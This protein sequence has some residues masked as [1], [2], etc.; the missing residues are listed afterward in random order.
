[1]N[2]NR[3]SPDRQVGDGPAPTDSLAIR[4]EEEAADSQT[5]AKLFRYGDV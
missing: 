5:E 3:A 2:R 4:L 1:M